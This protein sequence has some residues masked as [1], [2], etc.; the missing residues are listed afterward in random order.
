MSQQTC[1]Q[2]CDQGHGNIRPWTVA[3]RH[4]QHVNNTVNQ[5]TSRLTRSDLDRAHTSYTASI[6]LDPSNPTAHSAMAMIAQL[7]GDVR[8]AIRG[9]HTALSLGPQDPMATVLLEMALKEQIER[10]DPTTIPGLPGALGR[11]DLDPFAVPKVG[12]FRLELVFVR[13]AVGYAGHGCTRACVHESIG[14]GRSRT[15]QVHACVHA[16]SGTMGRSNT[17][18]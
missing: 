5:P 15:A 2:G 9:Y 4:C 18:A 13:C 1:Q 3:C 12:F 14:L 11:R 16:S 10:L 17:H 8:G 7:R 6:D